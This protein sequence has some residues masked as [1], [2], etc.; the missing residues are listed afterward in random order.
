MQKNNDYKVILV[1]NSSTGKTTIYKK[2]CS[3]TFTDKNISTIGMDKRTLIFKDIEVDIN[4]KKQKEDFY[5]I[6]Y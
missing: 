2:L 1:G 3:T 6:L 4:G 5:I